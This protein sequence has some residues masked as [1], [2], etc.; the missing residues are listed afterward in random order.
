MISIRY[1]AVAFINN[2]GK[3]LMMKRSGRSEIAKN[4]WAPVGG[5]LEEGEHKN[6]DEACFR[7]IYEET[8]ISGEQINS[9]DMK[10]IVM[11][12]KRNEIRIQ[13]V[14]FAD[15]D[16][17]QLIDCNEGSLHWIEDDELFKLKTTFTTKEILEEHFNNDST[18]SKIRVGIVD[19]DDDIPCMQW[20]SIEDWNNNNF[21]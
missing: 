9:L 1:F 3:H 5:H 10:Y 15:T 16:E 18:S 11:R 21:I 6:P 19:E 2:E 12:K 20:S 17:T 14:Y 8:G 4:M 13:Y 7:E